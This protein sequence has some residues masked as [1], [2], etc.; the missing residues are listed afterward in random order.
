MVDRQARNWTLRAQGAFDGGVPPTLCAVAKWL[1][2]PGPQPQRVSIVHS[3]F[4]LDNLIVSSETAESVALIDWDMGTLG[5]PLLDLATLLSYWAEPGDPPAMRALRQM[6]T[7]L[8]GFPSRADALALYA[9]RSGGLDVSYFKYY[10]VVALFKLC[11]VFQQIFQ[12]HLRGL[13]HDER[14]ASFGLL[15]AGRIDF[16]A[17][18]MA[19]EYL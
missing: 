11:V 6:P 10:R 17:E 15:V 1:A 19:S 18:A 13:T 4:K 8:P 3:D 2:R 7:A 16:T 9:T 12:R 5:D 14:A